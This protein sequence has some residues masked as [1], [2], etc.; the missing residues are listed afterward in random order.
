MV[1]KRGEAMRNDGYPAVLHSPGGAGGVTCSA[2]PRGDSIEARAQGEVVLSLPYGAMGITVTGMEDRYLCFEVPVDDGPARLLVPDREIIGHL[3]AIGAPR[4]VM[5]QLNAAVKKRARGAWGRLAVLA[6]LAGLLLGAV[7]LVWA[8]LGWAVDAV[9]EEIPPSWEVEIG[10]TSASRVLA[11][12]R[13]CADPELDA[14]IGEIGR[15]LVMGMGATPYQWRIR[16]LDSDDVNAFAL[17]GG[18]LFVNRGLIERAGSPH[19][20]GGVVAHEIQHVIHRHG[21]KNVVRQI[22]LAL[23]VYAVVGDGDRIQRFLVGNAASLASM[24]FSREQE[25]EADMSGMELV[26]RAGLEPTGLMTFLRKLAREEGILGE[27]TLLSTHPASSERAEDLAR[28]IEA[29]GAAHVE[30]FAGDWERTKTL[31]SPVEMT[32]PDQI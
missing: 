27:V 6:I 16:V 11:Q 10:R 9:V 12:N 13:V 7:L 22:G 8:A 30:P 24:S 18:Y 26:Y 23:I 21:M 19:E 2:H 25:T 31:C 1:G 3:E 4:R 29:R 5:D 17:P 14:A 15:R 32:D 20:V 28:L